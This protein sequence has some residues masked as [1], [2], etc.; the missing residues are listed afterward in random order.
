[1][2]HQETPTRRCSEIVPHGFG[3]ITTAGVVTNVS[4]PSI[5]GPESVAAGADGAMWFTN[6]FANS[7]GRISSSSPSVAPTVSNVSPNAGPTAGRQTVTITG[8]GFVPDS[9]VRFGNTL[10][11]HPTVVSA[12]QMTVVTPVR[13]AGTVNVLVTTA[14]G[15]SAASSG[16]RYL[17]G[18]PTVTS[19]GPD[20]GPIG[21]GTVVTIRGTNFV[22]GATVA[23]GAI[24]AASVTYTSSTTLPQQRRPAPALWTSPSPRRRPPVRPRPLIGT[25]SA[26]RRY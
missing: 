1:M 9:I 25:S 7:I 11:T 2:C 5:S 14:G 3:S 6:F 24:P 10:G 23:F 26:L 12:T 19:I 4:D 8:V 13:P 15:T 21:G 18:A 20:G 17:F 16:D 22:P